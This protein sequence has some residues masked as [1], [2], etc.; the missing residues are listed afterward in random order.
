MKISTRFS[1]Y[2][3][4]IIILFVLTGNV[5]AQWT[6]HQNAE[7]VIGQP[8]FTTYTSGTA[9]NKLYSPQKAAIDY[10]NNKMY[11]V[12]YSNHRVLRFA[13]PITANSPTAERV[14]GTTGVYGTATRNQFCYPQGVAVYNGTLWVC[15]PQNQRVVKFNNAHLASSDAPNADGVLGQADYTSRS[16]GTSQSK[17]NWPGNIFIDANGNLWVVDESN[18]R[19]LKFTDVN[20]KSEFS[21]PADFVLGQTDYTTL[22]SGVT[23]SKFYYPSGVIVSGTTV[24]ISDQY[25][26]R[27]LR[28]DNPT[29]NGTA[30]SAVLGQSDYTSNTS[31]SAANKFN[32]PYDV[33][34]DASGRLY[35][36]DQ[37]NGRIMIFNDAAN[38]S[39]GASADNVLGQPDLSTLG[40]TD[41]GQNNFEYYAA[42]QDRNVYG[43]TIDAVNNKLLVA[44]GGNNRVLQFA[45]NSPLPVELTSFTAN[46]SGGNVTLNWQTATE[47][48]ITGLR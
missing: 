23:Q 30:A 39:N 35:V 21:V 43:I 14:F 18:H 42:Y 22:T 7:Y 20:S 13:Y 41:G 29:T 45:A 32:S 33:T 3:A 27:V 16:G 37:S 46:V 4:L 5:T 24:W 40:T 8:D 38:K 34:I 28:F 10:T 15:D 36:S 31:G 17:F 26:H 47:K 44:D 48:T 11:V 6:N 9:N 12:D 2:I 19:V 25:N 1:I